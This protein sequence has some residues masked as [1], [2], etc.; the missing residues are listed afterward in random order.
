MVEEF[1]NDSEVFFGDVVLQQSQIRKIHDVDQS[2][3]A[4]GW[5][6]IR[7][8]SK[9]TGYGGRAYDKKT[10]DAMCTE[11]LNMK[12]MRAYVEDAKKASGNAEL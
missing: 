5:P 12:Y 9:S 6:T 11:L 7:H 8:Y 3:G 4:G 2:A 10:G 1:K